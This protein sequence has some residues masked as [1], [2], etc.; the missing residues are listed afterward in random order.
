MGSF[1]T[2]PF[3]NDTALDWTHELAAEGPRFLIATLARVTDADPDAYLGRRRCEEALAAVATVI[4]ARAG[5]LPVPN[6]VADWLTRQPPLDPD[7]DA[8][9]Q[10]A[11]RRI[12]TSSELA[13]FW[14]EAGDQGWKV[15]TTLLGRKLT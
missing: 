13:D 2:G 9:A 4:A 12:V 14:L 8:L 10:E 3:D 1:G 11:V 6:A 7:L 5:D 15:A